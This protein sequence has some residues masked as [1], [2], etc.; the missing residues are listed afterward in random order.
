MN[1]PS[2][3]GS[4]GDGRV[5]SARDNSTGGTLSKLQIDGS[6]SSSLMSLVSTLVPVLIY[7]VVCI[8]VFWI[9]RRRSHRV[10]SPRT[11][12]RSLFSHEQS[13]PLPKG[14]L[15]WVKPFWREPDTAILNRSTLDAFL[16]LRYLKVLALICFVGCCITWPTLMSIHASGGGGL[17]QLDRITIGNIKNSHI[18]FAHAI[19]AWIFF[20]FILFTIYREC[21]YYINLRHAYL[22]SPYYSKR[23]SSRT[24][25]FS[26]VPPKYMDAARLR[27][28]FGD[29]VKNVWIP[30]DT[31]DL[32]RLV[33]E[34]DETAARLE[35]AEIRLIKMANQRRNKQLKAAGVTA[36]E[37]VSSPTSSSR[38]EESADAEKGYPYHENT[39]LPD[40]N[41]SVAAQWIGAD[42][43]PYHRPLANFFRR[44]DTIKWTRN[45]IKALTKQINKLR[46]GFLK[47]EGRRLPAAFVEF[48]SQ[49]DAE[50]ACQTL[51]HNR[52]LH[53]SPR[54]IGMKP[55][56]IV[57]S[58]L[59]MQWF[60][61][62]V[63]GFLMRTAIATAIIFWSVPSAFVG[64]ISNIKFL[65]ETF[66]FLSWIVQLPDAVT[67]IIS[68]LLPALALSFLMAIVPW[69]LRGCARLA[70]V[71]SLSLIE[72]FV[73]HAYFA[74]QVVQVFLVTTLT[75]A[76]SAAFTQVLKDPLSAK[77]LLAENLPKASNFYISYILIQCLA[78][79]AASLVRA[80]D[81]VRHH[82]LAKSF[83][84]PRGLFRIWHRDR[85]IHWGAVF[86]VFT[87][88]GVI[89][90]SYSCIAPVVLGF[91]T[92]GFSCIY[93]VYKYNLMYVSSASIDTRGLVYPRALMHLLVGLYL[94]TICLIG[95]FV[96]REA[97]IPMVLMVAFL[98]FTALVH[99]SLREAVSPLLY[100]IPRA[101]AL[102]ME[103]LDGG[104]VAQYPQDDFLTDADINMSYPDFLD[105]IDE[106]EG[107][108][109]ETHGTRGVEG[110]SGLMVSVTDWSS[111][112]ILKKAQ[113]AANNWGLAR[114]LGYL[115]YWIA[116]DPS[117]KPNFL[118]HWLH[119][120]VFDDFAT[121][122]RLIPN[123]LPDPTATYPPDYARRAYWPP[124]MASPPP[125]LWIPRD[126]AGQEEF[127]SPEDEISFFLCTDN[128][129]ARY[130]GRVRPVLD[131]CSNA[132]LT[133][134]LEGD[135]PGSLKK[136]AW[137]ID[138]R[139][140]DNTWA[141]R[142]CLGAL[143][144]REL[145]VELL[146]QRYSTST[147]LEDSTSEA[148]LVDAERRLIYIN[149]LDRWS[150]LALVKTCPNSQARLLGEFFQKHLCARS[151]I[152]VSF[153]SN[154]PPMFAL[155]LH[156]PFRVWRKTDRLLMDNRIKV[157]TK[158]PLRSSRNL[159]FMMSLGNDTETSKVHGVYAGH[160]GCVVIGHDQNRWTT[161][162]A[163]D[164]WFEDCL[165]AQDKVM[166]Y[167]CDLEVDMELDPLSCVMQ[168]RLEQ[169]KDEWE[170]VLQNLD[171]GVSKLAEK[172]KG[173]RGLS[174]FQNRGERNNIENHG[175]DF[176]DFESFEALLGELKE[177]LQDLSQVL[178]QTRKTGEFFLATDVNFF[179]N[180]D[181]HHGD[182]S[183]CYPFL[184]EIRRK[185]QDIGQM[186]VSMDSLQ[187][188]CNY[189]TEDC[190]ATRRK[191]SFKDD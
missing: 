72:L 178:Q 27:K 125:V 74:F 127:D 164:T 146:K 51:A 11:I 1:I 136:V 124:E 4:S 119:P 148:P 88:M 40:V 76:A 172:Q 55:D 63:R 66:P 86:P 41:G 165:D 64:V 102:E 189:M 71:P 133:D 108:A 46:R 82:L 191:V 93:L 104:P 116:P 61:R 47:G 123:D 114:P 84:N 139:W 32:E 18:F 168:N 135:D 67:G 132:T 34:R 174:Q 9:L 101:L 70:G 81:V 49:A 77:D 37:T 20:G 180:Y 97:Y 106:S 30:R 26:C 79:G 50:R 131:V 43:R 130:E 112:Q 85:P 2:V 175:S 65:A 182:A 15:D 154:G 140:S 69:I 115:T 78:V 159:T 83:D 171:Q 87:N 157:S 28:V 105:P 60:E 184:A 129:S 179:L 99:I 122:R 14:W 59:R 53:M 45:R 121:L 33:K 38:S 36:P 134:L 187:T 10:Y 183:E 170:L 75:S 181:G 103:E 155:E 118:L 107:P 68:G 185:F 54:H 149:D 31:S 16:F 29:T 94:A 7:A 158:Q 12:L 142:P 13:I 173:L 21:I 95:L 153:A 89:A 160:M 80:F 56:E 57:W 17:T 39:V 48:S 128:E 190:E 120:G 167:Q 177:I 58:S 19:I 138:G 113:E 98:V 169:V 3:D 5:G 22:L 96:L 144:A 150:I 147:S 24:V 152:G 176:K 91:A 117:I 161:H 35:K 92:A 23:L 126:P 6:D 163:I 151:T 90:I 52:P 25:L 186:C 166:R 145:A 141:R 143:S 188:R 156:L 62:I 8:L 110:A 100:N 111:G 162:F 109:H 44:V 73:Q 137:L 42:E